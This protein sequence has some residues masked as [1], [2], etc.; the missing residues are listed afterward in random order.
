GRELLGLLGRCAW[1]RELLGLLGRRAWCGELLG[2]CA[3]G[4]ELLRLLGAL[5]PGGAV[6]IGGVGHDYS[7]WILFSGGYTVAT[8]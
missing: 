8:V 4:R 2:L 7:L 6:G 5:R 1:C 3:G